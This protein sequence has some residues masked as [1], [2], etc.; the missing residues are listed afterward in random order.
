[1]L[2]DNPKGNYKFL[3]G[4]GVPF[5]AGALADSG[6][7]VVHVSFKPLI[8]LAN[9]FDLIERHMGA[10]GR[11]VNAVCGIELRIP[12]ALSPAGFEEF[13]R[14]YLERI[15]AWGVMI[16]R[17]NPIARTNVAP[18]VVPIAESSLFG[19]YYTVPARGRESPG[20]VLAGA[21]EMISRDGRREVVAAGDVSLDGL[22]RKTACVLGTLGKLLAEMGREW[23]DTTAVNLYTV[24]DLHPLFATDLLPALG[25][26]GHR[27]IRWH[28]ARPPVQGLELEIDCYAAREELVLA[29]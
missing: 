13:N 28:F 3:K 21:P 23:N 18:A 22:R 27:G 5:S 25:S 12:S 2:L 7:E 4:A 14:H 20:L 29:R 24:H 16:D 19:F 26:A 17:L 9:G 6:F 10:V 11:P 1:M 8:P 15:R